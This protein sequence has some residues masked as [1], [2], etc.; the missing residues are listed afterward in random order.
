MNTVIEMLKE[1]L[2]AANADRAIKAQQI[3]ELELAVVHRDNL[4]AEAARQQQQKAG[5]GGGGDGGRSS[6]DGDG[7]AAVVG[8]LSGGVGAKGTWAA[9]SKT[10]AAHA[11]ATRE[12]RAISGSLPCIVPVGGRGAGVEGA[13]GLA[14]ARGDGE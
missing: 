5:G 11:A 3:S 6:P 1:Q 9:L 12:G 13:D 2:A 10:V 7:G 14:A 4:L 8:S